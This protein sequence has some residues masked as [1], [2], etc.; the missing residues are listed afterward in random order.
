MKALSP[1]GNVLGVSWSQKFKV[2]Q[3]YKIWLEL[4][5]DFEII[6]DYHLGKVDVVV[7]TLSRKLLVTSTHFRTTVYLYCWIWWL[8]E[9]AWIMMENKLLGHYMDFNRR[10][11]ICDFREM[12]SFP[13]KVKYDI[14]L[15]RGELE[16]IGKCWLR[17]RLLVSLMFVI[18]YA[19]KV[20][21][22]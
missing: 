16:K 6:T 9:L 17:K 3:R 13:S 8:W 2:N 18:R 7:D 20:Q 5:K 19:S 1:W 15:G 10:L 21:Q 11:W 12:F 14:I 22:H 4:I